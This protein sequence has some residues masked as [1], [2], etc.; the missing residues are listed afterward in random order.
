MLMA[1]NA[2]M[3]DRGSCW[4]VSERQSGVLFRTLALGLPFDG[5]GSVRSEVSLE[6]FPCEAYEDNCD[7]GEDHQRLSLL[8]SF[9]CPFAEVLGLLDLLLCVL[10]R[11]SRQHAR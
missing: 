5:D 1:K 9:L 3:N 2:A 7:D 4:F 8:R 10:S 11:G 6:L